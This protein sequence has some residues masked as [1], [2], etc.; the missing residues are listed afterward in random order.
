[1]TGGKALED[2]VVLIPFSKER[3]GNAFLQVSQGAV[4]FDDLTKVARWEIGRLEE[5]SPAVRLHGSVTASSTLVVECGPE[6]Q[7]QFQMQAA[8]TG[9]R[10]DQLTLLREPYQLGFKGVRMTSRS[11][12]FV[13]RS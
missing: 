2:V 13:I 3:C 7:L 8:V 11:S 12:S 10:V 5:T 4:Q 9:L 1:M 6:I